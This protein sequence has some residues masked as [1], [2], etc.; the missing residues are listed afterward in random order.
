M[1]F[2]PTIS[3]GNI[4][5]LLS[6]VGS[7]VLLTWKFGRDLAAKEIAGN[8]KMT[9]LESKQALLEQ[10]QGF[11]E[12][13][14]NED[15]LRHDREMGEIKSLLKEIYNKLDDKADKED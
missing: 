3:F 11:M 14:G 5:T 6:F 12:F 4:L 2:D 8:T 10:K 9:A 7:V 1:Q 13:T 15:R